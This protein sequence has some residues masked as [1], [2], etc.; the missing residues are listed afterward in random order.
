M[1]LSTQKLVALPIDGELAEFLESQLGND[2]GGHGRIIHLP[3]QAFL[4]L[5]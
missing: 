5:W 1:H 4:T 3:P 2:F